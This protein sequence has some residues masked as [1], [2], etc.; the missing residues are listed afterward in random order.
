MAKKTKK[1]GRERAAVKK[2]GARAGA[3]GKS[4]AKGAGEPNVRFSD[5]L[6]AGLADVQRIIRENKET[7]DSIQDV[8][9]QLVRVIGALED[10]VSRYVGIVDGF[11]DNAV[12]VL[13][14][15]PLIPEKTM[16]AITDIQQYAQKILDACDRADDV[17]AD[18]EAGLMNAD[19]NRLKKHTG[20]L[21][22]LTGALGRVLPGK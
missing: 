22:T 14:N 15:V 10:I 21:K 9:L 20:D 17:L 1:T 13:K 16:A 6:V 18:V 8:G 3:R 12:P 4:R 19:V 7:L 11:L 2:G 5:K